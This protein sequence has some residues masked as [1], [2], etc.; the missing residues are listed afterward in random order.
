M[1]ANAGDQVNQLQQEIERLKIE[2]TE[3]ITT[4]HK[5]FANEKTQ[6]ES[7]FEQRLAALKADY[8]G[9]LQALDVKKDGQKEELRVIMQERIDDLL[10]QIEA[11]K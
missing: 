2:H 5:N 9:Q 10:A 11:E 8:E 4:T 1:T 7:D 3:T 6:M